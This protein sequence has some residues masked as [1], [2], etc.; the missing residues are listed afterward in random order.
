VV[1]IALALFFSAVIFLG[2]TPIPVPGQRGQGAR[3]AQGGQRG[4]P[5]PAAPVHP[6]VAPIPSAVEVT[7]PGQFFETFMDTHDDEKNAQVPAKD[8]YARYNY[9]AK[10]YFVSGTTSQGKTY[11]TR[12]VVRKPRDNGRFNGLIVAE[13]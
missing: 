4:A 9:E 8:V 2:Q 3:G 5:Q 11:K 13:S 12:I 1:A 7:G 10:E 6:V